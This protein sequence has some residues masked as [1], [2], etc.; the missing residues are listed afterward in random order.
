MRTHEE[1]NIR[2]VGHDAEVCPG[3][4]CAASTRHALNSDN[5]INTIDNREVGEVPPPP[6][7][8]AFASAASKKS[9]YVYFRILHAYTIIYLKYRVYCSR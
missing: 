8:L 4:K 1:L 9:F 5:E 3:R 6:P 7:S 2:P